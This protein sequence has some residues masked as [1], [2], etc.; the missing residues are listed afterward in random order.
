MFD[1]EEILEEFAEAQ[2]M[3]ERRR[4]PWLP[5]TG[6]QNGLEALRR[7]YRARHVVMGLCMWC[8][9]HAEPGKKSCTYHLRENLKRARAWQ[10]K[11]REAWLAGRRARRAALRNTKREAP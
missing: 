1:A 10:E 3:I 11:N 9:K 5:L 4:T 2:A 6:K 7:A 8:P